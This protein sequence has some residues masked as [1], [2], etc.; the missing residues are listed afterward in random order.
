LEKENLHLRDQIKV[1]EA[2]HL[3]ELAKINHELSTARAD[4]YVLLQEKN[5]L[6]DQKEKL[7]SKNCDI[8]TKISHLE[9]KYNFTE[10]SND[11][12]MG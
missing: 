5:R 4:Y 2:F 1:I 7:S 3:G 10:H 11:T 6:V 8:R 9:Q 12:L